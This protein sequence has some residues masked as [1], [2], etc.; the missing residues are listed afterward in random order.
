MLLPY[1]D[2]NKL[3]KGL[4]PTQIEVSKRETHKGPS[5]NEAHCQQKTETCH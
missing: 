5:P 4:N 2:L 3:P 1:K